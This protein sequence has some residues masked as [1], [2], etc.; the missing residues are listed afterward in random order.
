LLHP[1]A[2]SGK[3]ELCLSDRH[4]LFLMVDRKSALKH[5]SLLFSLTKQVLQGSDLWHD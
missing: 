1:D 2:L 4:N 5:N 3:S